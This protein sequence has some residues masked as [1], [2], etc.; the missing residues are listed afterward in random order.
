MVCLYFFFLFILTTLKD[1]T[2]YPRKC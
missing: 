2:E 1:L